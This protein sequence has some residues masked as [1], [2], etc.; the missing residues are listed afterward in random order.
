M[1]D[2]RLLGPLVVMFLATCRPDQVAAPPPATQLRFTGQPSE[3]W[4]VAAI[5]P[6]V[7]ITALDGQGNT[8]TGFTEN[9][10]VAIGTNPGGGTLSGTMT[11]AAEN[12]VATFANLTINHAGAG[13]TLTASAAQLAGASSAPFDIAPPFGHVFIVVEENTNYDTVIGGTSMPYLNSLARQYVLATQ[14]YANTHPSIGNYFMLTVGDTVTNNDSYSGT[15]SEDNI[16][17]ELVAAGKTWKSYAEDLPSV[18]YTGPGVGNYARSHNP[19]AY[20]TDVVADT[21][22]AKNIV[23]FTEFSRDLAAGTL[24][25]YAMIVPNVCND[26][27]NCP[28]S[29]ADAWLQTN[30]DPLIKSASFQQDGLLVILFDEAGSDKTNGGGRVSWVAVSPNAKPGYQST[31]LYQH[32]STLRLSLQGLGVTVFP[33][34]AATAPA[35]TEFFLP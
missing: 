13:Y 29:T 4:P 2:L 14:Y 33:N 1:K 27:H 8:A 19:F 34:A 30:I 31:A 16:V 25:N 17:R 11:A 23:P 5:S 9:V 22:L 6:S 35:P 28:L 10:T 12:G 20:L 3:T 26:A 18:G 32:Q 24:P 7:Q 21:T 15:V